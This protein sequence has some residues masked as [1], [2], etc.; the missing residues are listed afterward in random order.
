MRVAIVTESF[1]P[2]VNG[3]TNSVL[4]MLEHLAPR[5]YD[6]HVITP[7]AGD[8]WHGD[9]PVTRLLSLP[10]PGYSAVAISLV[11]HRRLS[12]ILREIAPDVV[13]LASPFVVG[14]PAVRAASDLG[15]PVVAAFQTD[16]A[17]FASR[18]GLGVADA[19]V[20]RRLRRI[21]GASDLTLAPSRPT[22]HDLKAHDVPRVE[23][24]PRGV[25]AA[26]F[27]PTHRHDGLRAEWTGSRDD[28]VVGYVGRVAAEKEVEQLAVL[29]DIPGVTVVV[30]G[31]GPARSNLERLIPAGVFT[32]FLHGDE[33]SRA[34]A[35]LDVMVHTGRFET[36]CQSV[37][38][39]LASGVPVV[40]PASGG[41]LDLVTPSRNGWLYP[42][43]DEQ[44][45]RGHVL[46]LVG[47]QFKREAMGVAARQSVA[48]R[49]WCAVMTQ[50]EQ[51]YADVVAARSPA[52]ALR[53]SA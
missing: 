21:H 50:L 37:H 9:V 11:G 6:L 2:H 46:D 17:G 38:E 48:G 53:G 28:V 34:V 22:I 32:G 52:S 43:G 49:S 24:W 47:D 5:G 26:T 41:P 8:G 40:A 10:M 51:H 30:V 20:W 36:F 29:A 23:F 1:L 39:A 27:N 33:L 7:I 15:I 4:R 25:D 18:Y 13:H 12:A 45:L 44:A 42:P 3:V 19:M 14:V 31:D 35:S 16:V